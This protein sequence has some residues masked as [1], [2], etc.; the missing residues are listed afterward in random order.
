M[1]LQWEKALI[2]DGKEIPN[3]VHIAGDF[4]LDCLN[5]R[6][7]DSDYSLKSLAKMVLDC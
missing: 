6:W 1:L 7:L 2:F 5:G 3:E 4:N